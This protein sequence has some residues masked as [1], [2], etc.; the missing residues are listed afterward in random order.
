M[1]CGRPRGEDFENPVKGHCY[2]AWF[3]DWQS[4]DCWRIASEAYAKRPLRE[5]SDG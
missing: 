5:P 3:T 1:D 2:A 4:T